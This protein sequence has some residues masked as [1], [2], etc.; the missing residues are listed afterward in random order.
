MK[1]IHGLTLCFLVS[2]HLVA[3]ES[4]R[5]KNGLEYYLLHNETPKEKASIRLVLKVGMVHENENQKGFAHFVEHMTWR[6][7]ENF[8]EGCFEDELLSLGI[9]GPEQMVSWTGVDATV[10]RFNIDLHDP[11]AL[12]RTLL[13]I[14]EMVSSAT[15]LPAAVE[16]EREEVMT[17]I[18]D[19]L[20]KLNLQK[21]QYQASLLLKRPIQFYPQEV[22]EGT[23]KAT[24]EQLFNFYQSK[25]RPDQMALILVG[26]F[27]EG[28]LRKNVEKLFSSLVNPTPE[29]ELIE[30]ES[31][32]ELE[33]QKMTYLLEEHESFHLPRLSVTYL[34]PCGLEQTT[35][36][37]LLPLIAHRLHYFVDT[38][39]ALTTWANYTPLS[40]TYQLIEV[41]IVLFD[42]TAVS[43]HINLFINEIYRID[44][45][46][47]TEEDKI[48][49][50][51]KVKELAPIG[52]SAYA[53][54]YT[55]QF[56]GHLSVMPVQGRYDKDK[57][58][59]LHQILKISPKVLTVAV[60]SREVLD[61]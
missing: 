8:K 53:K 32:L 44:Q 61:R 30:Q 22:L 4:G 31:L 5:L 60:R 48:S 27:D 12:E 2:V 49:F 25:Y 1:L 57:M 56:L 34:L 52:N 11:Q 10:F 40:K 15:F 47:F 54:L 58:Q 23:Q 3:L 59:S 46:G 55:D 24:S 21:I 20:A 50:Q 37:A 7:T 45:L 29:K 39:Y 26:D 19:E 33:P 18:K 16:D 43:S 41:G 14:K 35:R 38:K 36:E 13:I 28:H 42:E 17:D 51:G 6:G 9:N